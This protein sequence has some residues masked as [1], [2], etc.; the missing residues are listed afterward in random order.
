LRRKLTRH[1]APRAWGT[2]SWMVTVLCLLGSGGC[3]RILRPMAS[4]RSST[5]GW[6]PSLAERRNDRSVDDVIGC[7]WSAAVVG[8][9][10]GGVVR[11]ARLE[12][13][14]P[15]I[16]TKI[17]TERLRK[18]LEYGLVIRT[19][20]PGRVQHVEYTLTPMGEKLASV[21]EQVQSLQ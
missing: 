13:Y 16:S 18:L 10:S 7:E 17:L 4:G 9:L 2:M 6:S 3:G 20:R 15:G 19:E 1:V 8:A 5:A 12:R 21:I 11:A 14:S